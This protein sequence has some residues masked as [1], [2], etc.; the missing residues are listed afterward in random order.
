MLRKKP[1]LD[2]KSEESHIAAIMTYE[3]AVSEGYA[4]ATIS[5]GNSEGC[6]GDYGGDAL[7][8]YEAKREGDH[9]KRISGYCKRL[10]EGPLLTAYQGRN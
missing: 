1:V 6:S 7:R 9:R 3:T 10:V 4:S 8:V 2:S 5:L